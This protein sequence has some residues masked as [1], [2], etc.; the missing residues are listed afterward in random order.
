MSDFKFKQD[1]LVRVTYSLREDI[2]G[3][4]F[5]VTNYKCSALGCCGVLWY[6]KINNYETPW[7]SIKCEDK[8]V[9][10]EET[11][12]ELVDGFDKCELEDYTIS[13]LED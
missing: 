11:S 5:Y 12:L 9:W 3:K 6:T 1:D 7:K 10:I 4:T 13:I 2:L 8:N